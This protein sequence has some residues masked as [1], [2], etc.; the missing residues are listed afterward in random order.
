MTPRTE[1]LRA[2]LYRQPPEI[3]LERARIYTDSWRETEG[4]P[5]VIRRAMAISRVLREMTIHICEKELLVGNHASRP[6]AVPLFPEFSA[7]WFKDEMETFA[8]RPQDAFILR[9]EDKEA[10]AELADYWQGKTHYDRMMG[11]IERMLPPDVAEACDQHHR[12]GRPC[13]ARFSSNSTVRI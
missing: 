4:K 1:K 12:R 7:F 5:L 10:F 2:R 9:G 13:G 8:S 11:N 3:C 6:L